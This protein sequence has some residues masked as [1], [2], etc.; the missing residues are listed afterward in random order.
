MS[1]RAM[2]RKGCKVPSGESLGGL[3]WQIHNHFVARKRW[4]I[5]VS[6]RYRADERSPDNSLVCRVAELLCLA[7]QYSVVV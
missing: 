1:S 5:G 2:R 4:N 6:L 7:N 3:D